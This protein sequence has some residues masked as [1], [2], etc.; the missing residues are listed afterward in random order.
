LWFIAGSK[1]D[2]K[3]HRYVLIN[4]VDGT[5]YTLYIWK[6]IKKTLCNLTKDYNRQNP[7]MCNLTKDYSR[8]NPHSKASDPENDIAGLEIANWL[9]DI[10]SLI[11]TPSLQKM[12][13]TVKRNMRRNH[14]RNYSKNKGRACE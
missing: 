3:R 1:Y 9:K 14:G 5:P 13:L 10:S 2:T 4:R 7:H 8:Q 6:K 12:C 11:I